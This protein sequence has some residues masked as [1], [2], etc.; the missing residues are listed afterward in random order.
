RMVPLTLVGLGIVVAFQARVFNIGAEGQ[1]VA[2]AL[3]ATAL[4]LSLA[5]VPGPLL[6]PAALL[7]GAVAGACW[8]GLAGWLKARFGVNEILSTV[9][10][11]QIALQGMYF[12]LRGPMIDPEELKAGTNIAQSAALPTQVWLP[13][14][15]RTLLHA[16]ILLLPLLAAAV[17]VLLRRTAPGMSF[18][19]VGFNPAAARYAGVAV[20]TTT[21]LAM[22]V[23]GG[24]AG[25]A[26]AVEVAGIHH[27]AVEGMTGGAGFAGIV[28]ALLGRLHPLG[29][30]PAS[31]LFAALLVGADKMQRTMQVPAALVLALQ[32]L[33][34]C[35]LVCSEAWERRRA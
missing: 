28:A 29:L 35:F 31:L 13:R 19:A 7:T 20:G 12:L 16:G 3:A 26:G 22:A 15:P 14:A 18:R 33:V 9:M 5:Q 25:L 21:V 1:M 24:L 23:S 6:L 8:G 2:G 27:R 4:A 11:N 10:L 30:L 32:G 34:L 17:Y